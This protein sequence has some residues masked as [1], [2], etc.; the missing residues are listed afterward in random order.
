MTLVLL[1]YSALG[2]S[3]SD[4]AGDIALTVDGTPVT[5]GD[6]RSSAAATSLSPDTRAIY[7]DIA[8]RAE[9]MALNE[10]R[11]AAA[12]YAAESR[13]AHA[14]DRQAAG[15]DRQIASARAGGATNIRVEG[16]QIVSFDV[17]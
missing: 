5:L 16:G 17:E 15:L 12:H 2:F 14:E 9:A 1:P 8:A 4:L 7:A 6:L 13:A 10:S 11:S 3:L